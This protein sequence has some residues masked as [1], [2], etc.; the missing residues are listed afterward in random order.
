MDIFGTTTTAET[1]VIQFLGVC[2][3]FSAEAASLKARLDKVQQSLRKIERK[4]F[5]IQHLI[6]LCGL[7]DGGAAKNGKGNA[8]VDKEIR[9][10]GEIR[11]AIATSDDGSDKA[12]TPAVVKSSSRLQEFLALTSN[13]KQRLAKEMV[14]QEAQELLPRMSTISTQPIEYYGEQLIFSCRSAPGYVQPPSREFEALLSS[15]SEL[16]AALNCLDASTDI[17]LLKVEFYFYDPNNHQFLFAQIPP[18]SVLS[19]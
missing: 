8:P 15:M 16:A 10:A 12:T 1:L 6:R 5:C 11:I 9:S 2:S 3:D 13:A 7:R 4:G 17:Q 19:S 18:Y 14:L